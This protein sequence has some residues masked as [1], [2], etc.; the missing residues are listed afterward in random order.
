MTWIADIRHALRLLARS[1][2]FTLTSVL[3]LSAGL[4]VPTAVFS[5]ADALLAPAAGVRDPGR[6]VD[7][8]RGND[9]RGFDNMSHPAFEYLR[10]HATSFEGMAGVD[11]GG[12]PMSLTVDG[13]SERVFGTLV[14]ANFFE[15]LGT[16]LALG[17][18]FRADED[19]RA[20]RPPGRGADPS[21][22]VAAARRRPGRA[23]TDTA[24]QRRTTSPSSVWRVRASRG[25][26]WPAP[27]CGCRWP[28]WPKPAA[29]RP[30]RC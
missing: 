28:W 7:I 19:A 9:G 16:P 23:R 2:L 26:A 27:T 21:L 12:R 8:G 29:C 14:S 25:R 15:V 22:L 4:A 24:A 3:S 1:P 13:T 11:F 30:P 5:L 10:Q 20:R 6:V 17:R 18:G